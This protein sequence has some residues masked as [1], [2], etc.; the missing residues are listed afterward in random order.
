MSRNISWVFGIPNNKCI[1]AA[2]FHR[3]R[4]FWANSKLNGISKIEKKNPAHAI[5]KKTKINARFQLSGKV[6]IDTVW[7]KQSHKNDLAVFLNCYKIVFKNCYKITSHS[8]LPLSKLYQ[9]LVMYS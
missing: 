5:D 9:F 4:V 1:S 6:T 7:E 3:K 8:L 2:Q